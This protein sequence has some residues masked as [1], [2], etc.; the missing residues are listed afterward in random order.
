MKLLNLKVC[1]LTI[2]SIIEIIIYILWFRNTLN[3]V[4]N[5]I[6]FN[7]I[8]PNIISTII[9]LII[10]YINNIIYDLICSILVLNLNKKLVV[11]QLENS[12]K[13]I[14]SSNI[15][16]GENIISKKRKVA[17]TAEGL[18]TVIYA[19]KDLKDN[20][21]NIIKDACDYLI[22]KIDNNGLI[23]ITIK[24][25]TVQCTALGLYILKKI[26]ISGVNQLSNSQLEK[27]EILS[28]ALFNSFKKKSYGWETFTDD[29]NNENI[30]LTT[31]LWALRALN[32][33][34]YSSFN[35]FK[36]T[37]Y[38]LINRCPQYTFGYNYNDKPRLC[39]IS[40]FV[41]IINEINNQELKRKLFN[42]INWKKVIHNIFNLLKNTENYI[43]KEDFTINK[44]KYNFSNIKLTYNHISIGYAIEALSLIYNKLSL[45]Y[46]IK[47][48]IILNNLL[49][50]GFNE[51]GYYIENLS[52][53]KNNILLYPTTY[54]IEGIYSYYKHVLGG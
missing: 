5:K 2:I 34:K 11:R 12:K 31:T 19:H 9:I 10:L 15:Y 7:P 13:W 49:N 42:E 35:I 26:S 50:K 20:E 41:I 44:V 28:N 25:A 18:F 32:L 47:Y 39:S 52:K 40:L 33:S 27:I 36:E 6:V 51:E 30:R 17:N 1:I 24:G 8:E 3:S 48:N 37:I 43:E 23:S 29:P 54:L 21:K 4:I 16:W 45:K 22:D 53:D 14:Y 46:K 38:N